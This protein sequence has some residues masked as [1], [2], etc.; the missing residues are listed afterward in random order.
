M[1]YILALIVGLGSVGLYMAAFFFPEVY[2]KN[3]FVLS[4]IGMF[5]ALV[6]WVCAGRMTGGV[7]LGQVASV[8]LLGWLAWQ[9]LEMRR[10]L[11]PIDQQTR[12]P[13]SARTLGEV[14]RKLAQELPGQ[15]QQQ[16]KQVSLP[17]ALGGLSKRATRAMGSTPARSPKQL[18]DGDRSLQPTAKQPSAKS[19][20]PAKPARKRPVKSAK[21]PQ[22]VEPP[23]ADA[24]APVSKVS[25]VSEVSELERSEVT[26]RSEVMEAIAPPVS[27]SVT[28]PD[29]PT[30]PEAIRD[31]RRQ[32][33]APNPLPD[34]SS[35]PAAAL[36]SP[37]A[38]DDDFDF[39]DDM[40]PT[41]ATAAELRQ[42]T[43]Q[44]AAAPR[45]N[46]FT[47]LKLRLQRGRNSSQRS[48]QPLS[49]DQIV[50]A[51]E[52]VLESVPEVALEIAPDA[53]PEESAPV[54]AE[55]WEAVEAIATPVE[56]ETL[57]PSSE[58]DWDLDWAEDSATSE[59]AA[60]DAAAAEFEGTGFPEPEGSVTITVAAETISAVDPDLMPTSSAADEWDL[61]WA[62]EV[63][64][65][66]FAAES[67]MDVE[68]DSVPEPAT[69]S[70]AAPVAEP[71]PDPLPDSTTDATADLA[72]EPEFEL[73]LD[74]NL[75][76][77]LDPTLDGDAESAEAEWED[78]AEPAAD[79]PPAVLP[80]LIETE[81]DPISEASNWPDTDALACLRGAR[82][83]PS[84]ALLE[85]L[86]QGTDAIAFPT[87]DFSEL[88]DP[89]PEPEPID[90]LEEIAG[91][92]QDEAF[93]FAVLQRIAPPPDI[94]Q[95]PSVVAESPS[96]VAESPSV[97][98]ESPSVMDESLKSEFELTDPTDPAD[99]ADDT[100]TQPATQPAG[101][102]LII[103]I[104]KL[105]ASET[106][107]EPLPDPAPDPPSYE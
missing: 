27:D 82:I 50:P 5:Y 45:P 53:N 69:E 36:E 96:V 99:P 79:Q 2:R 17:T 48:P 9:S 101:H 33:N 97:I 74:P 4:G 35:T 67:L 43:A 16:V 28:P 57:T 68:S 19:A 90:H 29:L 23:P 84:P 47:A 30:A 6:L 61:G 81:V 71:V 91:L 83:A 89:I 42:L 60:A 3:D 102:G 86:D 38:S 93:G 100:S 51:P 14:L 52:S 77:N 12:L 64:A 72:A 85:L 18:Q 88:L 104:V 80:L 32:A 73:D 26:E 87:E 7:L 31:T 106:T 25:E 39:D 24:I 65:A 44:S 22:P 15:L 62:Q 75:D 34:E 8:T 21:P 11:T 70:L 63:T 78:W 56:A 58:A 95:P 10:S 1:A 49:A 37:T 105:E 55:N 54:T 13:G 92:E 20:K 76:S 66:E 59:V 103:Q 46:W 107:S 98:D 94:D 41:R 40:T